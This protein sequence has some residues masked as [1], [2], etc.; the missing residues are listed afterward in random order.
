MSTKIKQT[1]YCSLDIETSEFDP[2]VGEIL[3]IGMVF[4]HLRKDRVEIV[5]EYDAVFK[6]AKQVAPRILA[7]TGITE[8]ELVN[9]R[10]FAEYSK[11]IQELVKDCVIVGHN[12]DFDTKFLEAFGIK[13]SG[14]KIDTINLAQIFLPTFPSYNLEGLM[15]FLE[16]EHKNAHRAL[17]DAK[18]SLIV[19]E[20]LLS[21]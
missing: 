18:A 1:I 17:A 5:K 3:E 13:F 10:P 20:K 15:N 2:S 21:Y 16:V 9:A 19:M 7:L 4:F 11:E 6:P 8:E 12:I 14:R